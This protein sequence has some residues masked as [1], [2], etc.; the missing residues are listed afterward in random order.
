MLKLRMTVMVAAIGLGLAM[1]A[2]VAAG[3]LKPA[4]VPVT[5]ARSTLTVTPDRAWNKGARPGRLSEAWTL[6]GLNINELTFYGGIS[7]NTTL[8]REVNKTTIPLPRLTGNYER[9]T[10]RHTGTCS[11]LQLQLAPRASGRMFGRDAFHGA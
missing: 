4:G 2:P 10:Q 6:D 8:F 3:T 7:D 1:A 11:T 9:E 5:V